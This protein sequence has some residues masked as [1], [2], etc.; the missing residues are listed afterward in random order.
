MKKSFATSRRVIVKDG[1]KEAWQGNR[2]IAYVDPETDQLCILDQK[3]YVVNRVE[4][5]RHSAI[6]D[7]LPS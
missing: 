1:R 5:P 2:M 3:G 4:I 7:A 6:L